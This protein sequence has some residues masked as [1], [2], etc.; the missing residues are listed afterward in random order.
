MPYNR[1]MSKALKTT[2]NRATQADIDQQSRH[3][4]SLPSTSPYITELITLT[5]LNEAIAKLAYVHWEAR[6]RP[7]GSPQEDWFQAEQELQL[8]RFAAN[9]GDIL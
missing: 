2:A 5:D 7:E 9:I 8:I 4:V 1:G 6:G 3:D